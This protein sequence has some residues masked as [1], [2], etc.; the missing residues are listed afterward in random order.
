MNTEFQ[1]LTFQHDPETILVSAANESPYW[2]LSLPGLLQPK[3][4][5]VHLEEQEGDSCTSCISLGPTGHPKLSDG[6][7]SSWPGAQLSALATSSCSSSILL[8]EG[9][10]WHAASW[11]QTTEIKVILQQMKTALDQKGYWDVTLHRSKG[12]VVPVPD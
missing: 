10:T 7:V 2:R 6:W 11:W 3:M 12:K 4:N 1:H 9:G 5:G 8:S